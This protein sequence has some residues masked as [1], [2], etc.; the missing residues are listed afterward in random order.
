MRTQQE[1]FLDLQEAQREF[2]RAKAEFTDSARG[3]IDPMQEVAYFPN[4]ELIAARRRLETARYRLEQLYDEYD[5]YLVHQN[6]S[7]GGDEYI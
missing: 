5:F 3:E 1:I 6:G 2:E 7:Q 4:E